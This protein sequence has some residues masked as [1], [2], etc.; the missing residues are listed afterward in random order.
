MSFRYIG[1]KSR[2]VDQ[3]KTRIGPST[4]GFFVDAFCGT[5]VVAEAAADLGWPVRIN[6]NLSSAVISAG[7]RLISSK[8][9]KFKKLGRGVGHVHCRAPPA[10]GRP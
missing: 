7:A 10:L 8:E 4:G 1:S 6:D 3:I 2:I 9:A 5:G